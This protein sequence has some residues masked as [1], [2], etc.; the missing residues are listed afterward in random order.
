M[1]CANRSMDALRSR[2]QLHDFPSAERIFQLALEIRNGWSSQTRAR[3]AAAGVCRV[4]VLL[5]LAQLKSREQK[6]QN[7]FHR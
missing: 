6:L 3:R 4:D 7:R 2:K 1:V 5:A